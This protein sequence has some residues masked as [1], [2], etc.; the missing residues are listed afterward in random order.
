MEDALAAQRRW[1]AE[2]LQL[3]AS[4]RRT[5]AIIEAFAVVPREAFLGPGPW[6]L[7]P[8]GEPH[9]PF[10]TPDNDPRWLYH[11]VLVTIDAG[12][13]L[14]NGQ[15]SLWARI[16]DHLELHPGRRVMQIGAGLGYYTAVLAEIV[17][18]HGHVTAVECDAEL[19]TRAQLNLRPWAQ[20]EVAHGDGCRHDPGDVDTIIVCAGA[21]HPAPLWL[22]RLAPGGHLLLPLT[23]ENRWGFL[24]RATRPRDYDGAAIVLES[25][26]DPNRFDATSIGQ[27]GIY[28]CAGGRDEAAAKRLQETLSTP[29]RSAWGAPIPIE[30]LHRGD[31]GPELIDQV[32][33]HGPGF[34]LERKTTTSQ[35]RAD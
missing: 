16:F 12:R 31:P 34:W 3:R 17:G 11:D 7:L 10:A 27:V 5:A 14:N 23:T 32:W 26:R 9:L 15:P 35:S 13:A 24:L 2:D 18:P 8:P 33:Y 1:Y 25:T 30:A 4:V 6:H 20:V 28:P 21:T 29:N 19:A 22:D